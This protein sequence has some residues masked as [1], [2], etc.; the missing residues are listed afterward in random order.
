M[1]VGVSTLL[2]EFSQI[3]IRLPKQY[4]NSS[5]MNYHHS[6]RK[7]ESPNFQK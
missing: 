2:G 3:K 5:V 4:L 1:D 6:V 7:S